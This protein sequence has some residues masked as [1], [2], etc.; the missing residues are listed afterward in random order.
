MDYFFTI[1]NNPSVPWGLAFSILFLGLLAWLLLRQQL[2]QLRRQLRQAQSLLN[3]I[4]PEEFTQHYETVSDA[5]AQNRLL[6]H[7]WQSFQQTLILPTQ[8]QQPICTTQRPSVYFNDMTLIMPHVNLSLYQAVPNMLV[9]IGLFFTFIGLVAALWFAS[10]GVAAPDVERAQAALQDLLHAATFKF[11]TSIAGLLASLLFSWREKAQLHVLREDIH[12]LAETMEARL[13]FLGAEQL[14]TRQLHEMEKQTE[15]LTRFNSDFAVSIANALED[16]IS[17][18][19]LR[20]MEPLA[21]A[22]NELVNKI[23]NTNQD[24]IERMIEQ[25]TA[26]LQGAAGEEMKELAQSLKDLVPTMEALRENFANS[27]SDFGHR[28][29]EAATHLQHGFEQAADT[30]LERMT[31]T[32]QTLQHTTV[33]E[34]SRISE[35]VEQLIRALEQLRSGLDESGNTLHKRLTEAAREAST[36]LTLSGEKIEQRLSTAALQFANSMTETK[37][38]FDAVKNNLAQIL[39]DGVDAFKKSTKQLQTLQQG[40]VTASEQLDK[41][42]QP[43]RDTT[44]HLQHTVEQLKVLADSLTQSSSMLSE[45]SQTSNTHLQETSQAVTQVWQRYQGHF[46]KIDEDVAKVFSE[47][48]TGVENYRQQVE[49]FTKQLDE[50]L[51]SAVKALGSVIMELVE[52]IEDLQARQEK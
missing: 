12:H 28:I 26:K 40:L 46:E 34:I 20:A 49:G 37:D 44:D 43:L 42:N 32:H 48:S 19:L 45:T 2:Q 24:A 25:F 8:P 18:R 31:N 13:N 17:E 30:L 52:A 36:T 14:A 38:N 4:A 35:P 1:I 5:L 6:A 33:N 9:G 10:E 41:M 23:G 3:N 15:Q 51:N 29:N 27:G 21:E 7:P 39:T 22:I 47:L 11:V 16:K 50:S